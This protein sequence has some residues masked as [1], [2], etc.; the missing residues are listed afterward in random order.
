[1]RRLH[2]I[3]LG[4]LLFVPWVLHRGHALSARDAAR[5]DALGDTARGAASA[6]PLPDLLGQYA[7]SLSPTGAITALWLLHAAAGLVS[8]ML[9]HRLA[10]RHT[11]DVGAGLACALFATSIPLL[12]QLGG[13]GP[14][15]LVTALMLGTLLL[16]THP[17]IGLARSLGLWVTGGALLA[18]YPPMLLWASILLLVHRTSTEDGRETTP[19]GLLLA[20]VI[21][22]LVSTLMHPALRSHPL[23][24]WGSYMTATFLE[25]TPPGIYLGTPITTRLPWWSGVLDLATTLPIAVVLATLAGTWLLARA[26]T[27]GTWRTS[28]RM[29]AVTPWL[30][31]VVPWIT[32]DVFIG[33]MDA[34]V[35]PLPFLCILAAIAA[36]GFMSTFDARTPSGLAMHAGILAA[37]LLP[38]PLM[39]LGA[40]GHLGSTHSEALGRPGSRARAYLP[41]SRDGALKLDAI[42]EIVARTG[43]DM[44]SV[45]VGDAGAVLRVMNVARD[46]PFALAQSPAEADALLLRIDTPR[47]LPIPEQAGWVITGLGPGDPSGWVV[48]VRPPAHPA[49]PAVVWLRDPPLIQHDLRSFGFATPG[50]PGVPERR[51]PRGVGLE[52]SWVRAGR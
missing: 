51:Q 24:G 44:P 31:L 34:L 27:A 14:G 32:G 15:T 19:L 33:A 5:M 9:V 36:R 4:A 23:P 2:P 49:R 45:Y 25:S 3:A 18:S 28:A 50:K 52:S 13:T 30:L 17:R 48:Y 6:H 1:M 21:V 42:D 43:K 11:D 8:L 37:L 35:P 39:H 26:R 22:P 10:M 38:A 29:L 41:P 7:I 46:I 16:G 40:R 47:G 12:A 20:P